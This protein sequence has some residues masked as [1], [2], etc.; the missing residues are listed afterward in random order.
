[1][2]EKASIPSWDVL[3]CNAYLVSLLPVED[4][5]RHLPVPKSFGHI[6][7]C[8]A[9]A[10]LLW[11]QKQQPADKANK[12]NRR[13]IS[14]T[15]M[16]AMDWA[17]TIYR[18]VKDSLLEARRNHPQSTDALSPE[19]MVSSPREQLAQERRQKLFRI[20][21]TIWP[22]IR[23]ALWLQL[24]AFTEEK[25]TPPLYTVY[26]HRRWLHEEGM[27]LYPSIVKPLLRS[28]RETYQWMLHIWKELLRR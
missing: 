2:S 9:A 20:F 13:R 25:S 22:L 8:A 16:F 17:P 4:A 1:M 18:I 19:R 5:L 6:L 12:W 3:S 28:S 7:R 23:L 27:T 11:N 24:A 15:C 10:W 26:A 14:L 21:G